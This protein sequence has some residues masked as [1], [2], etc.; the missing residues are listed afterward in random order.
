[1]SQKKQGRAAP[2]F[3]FHL[4]P[5]ACALVATYAVVTTARRQPWMIV[6]Y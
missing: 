3:S 6:G 2:A 5:I 4:R 1:M